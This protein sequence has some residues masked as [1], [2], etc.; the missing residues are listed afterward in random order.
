M[1]GIDFFI[2][3]I[4]VALVGISS[5]WHEKER[6]KAK[7]KREQAQ[8]ALLQKQ[9]KKRVPQKQ[10]VR[11]I[12][13]SKKKERFYQLIVPAVHR[14]HQEWTMRYERLAQDL[15]NSEYAQEIELLQERYKAEDTQAL[16]ASLKPH[17]PSITIAQA[18][19]E[20][21]WATSRFFVEANNIFGVWSVG[22][23]KPR[24]AASEQRDNNRTIWLRKFESVD[25]AVEEYY[26]M[27]ARVAAYEEFRK[28]RLLSDD[29]YEILVHLDKYS[30]TGKEYTRKIASLIR[31]N[32][33]RK[34]DTLPSHTRIP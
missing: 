33:L 20:S 1:R 11:K 34:F 23:S 9:V 5:L 12:S 32:K 3:L 26:D 21:A 6:Q 10:E 28:T 2:V 19:I 17:P 4:I 14:V 16:L 31:Y 18:A 25:E 15:N 27:M 29:P 13:V 24:I 30:E 22:S 8:E 7:E